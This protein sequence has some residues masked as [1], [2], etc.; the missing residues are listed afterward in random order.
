VFW[1]MLSPTRAKLGRSVVLAWPV[2]DREPANMI[3]L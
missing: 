2:A 3:E 1:D